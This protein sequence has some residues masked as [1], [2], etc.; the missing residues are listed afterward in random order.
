VR[1]LSLISMLAMLIVLPASSF[2]F[3]GQNKGFATAQDMMY[4]MG[5]ASIRSAA[6]GNIVVIV[7]EAHDGASD[8]V[9]D[10]IFRFA[11]KKKSPEYQNTSLDIQNVRV[12][13]S[14]S[15]VAIV[16]QE[17]RVVVSLSLEKVAKDDPEFYLYGDRS[18]D[19]AGAIRIAR[20]LGLKRQ[21]PK[22]AEDG[23]LLPINVDED[24]I[25]RGIRTQND[26]GGGACS[27]GG[28]GATSC[29]ISCTGGTG[30]SVS[31][32]SGLTAC[33]NCPHD[34]GCILR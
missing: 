17:G 10:L 1:K 27:S 25:S 13:F 30:C 2:S 3:G 34:C 33:C 9:P 12:H 18:K 8:G 21:T 26:P 24:F 22:R 14:A 32:S 5:N 6:N 31:C 23:S 11:P 15:R 16:S 7:D 4:V 20:G 28:S 29:S 19:I